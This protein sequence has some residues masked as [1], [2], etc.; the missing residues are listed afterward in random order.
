[1][2]EWINLIPLEKATLPLSNGTIRCKGYQ[3]MMSWLWY[4]LSMF[5]LS[6]WVG[7]GGEG[8]ENGGSRSPAYSRHKQTALFML[9]YYSQ[10]KLF[11]SFLCFTSHG[12]GACRSLRSYYKCIVQ[13]QLILWRAL[14][15]TVQWIHVWCGTME[16]SFPI[17]QRLSG[18]CMWGR[19]GW[20]DG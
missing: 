8:V 4:D 13:C 15:C 6:V 20:L 16:I 11:L 9:L 10:L 17:P 2:N 7:G 12:R 18:M 14:H 1:M 5:S 3:N 19:V